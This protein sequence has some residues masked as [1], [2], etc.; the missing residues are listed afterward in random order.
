MG[1]TKI[2]VTICMNVCNMSPK[3]ACNFQHLFDSLP[4]KNWFEKS[5]PP[6]RI[7]AP[8]SGSTKNGHTPAL[9]PCYEVSVVVVDLVV[10]VPA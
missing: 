6:Q 1:I 10:I 3:E 8:D 9:E 5:P 7:Y 2:F 4:Q